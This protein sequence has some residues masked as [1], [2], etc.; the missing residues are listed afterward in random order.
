[1]M[2]SG[3]ER[4]FDIE[5]ADC[6]QESIATGLDSA[7][8][9]ALVKRLLS[10]RVQDAV[11]V[12]K[13]YRSGNRSPLGEGIQAVRKRVTSA[14]SLVDRATSSKSPASSS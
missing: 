1:M 8:A 12:K 4:S 13:E 11:E 3:Q 7:A 14:Q 5:G 10:E 6:M 2:A 9:D